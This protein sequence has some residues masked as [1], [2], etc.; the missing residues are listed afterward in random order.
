M[1]KI[2]WVSLL[3]LL[4][5]LRAYAQTNATSL[6]GPLIAVNTAA[7]DQIVLFDA[8]NGAQRSLNLGDGWVMPWDFTADGCRL[9]YTMSDGVALGR[10]YSAK[11]DGSDKRSL[12]QF[13]DLPPD[14]WGLWELQ[15]SP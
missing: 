2:F 13:T 4:S 9:I 10:V 12:V 3:F 11:L 6:V 1:R 15:A 14:A 8:S 7:Q 5:S